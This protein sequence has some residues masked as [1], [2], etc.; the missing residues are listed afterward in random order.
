MMTEMQWQRFAGKPDAEVAAKTE[1]S[2]LLKPIYAKRGFLPEDEPLTAFPQ[3][4]RYAMLDEIGR[5]LP[6]LLYPAIR[7]DGPSD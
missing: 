4:S 6:S 1:N 3:G 2:E 5:D 7:P